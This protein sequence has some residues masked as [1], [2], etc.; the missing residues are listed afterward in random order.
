[1]KISLNLDAKLVK[2]RPYLLNPEYKEKVHQDLDKMLEVG[3]IEPIGESNWVSSMVVQEK[4]QKGKLRICIDLQKLNDACVHD[5][6]PMPFI[7][8]V[9]DNVGE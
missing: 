6:F 5:P 1:M 9:L 2:Q 3:I 7:Y 4:K 8:E